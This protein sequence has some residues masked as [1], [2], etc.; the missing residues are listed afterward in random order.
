MEFQSGRWYDVRIRVT[1]EKIQAWLDNRQIID[2]DVK[3]NE[4]STRIEM[5]QSKPIG[6]ASWRTKA[7]LRDIKI[8]HLP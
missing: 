5:D 8:R 4:I 6:V 7:A 2:V 3:D 1:P